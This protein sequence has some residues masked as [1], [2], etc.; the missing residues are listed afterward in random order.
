MLLFK[1]LIF[2]VISIFL[3][4]YYIFIKI[5]LKLS[6]KLTKLQVILVLNSIFGTF[7]IDISLILLEFN[8]K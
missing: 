1:N 5:L 2:N 3:T 7:S 6:I 4:F 8:L